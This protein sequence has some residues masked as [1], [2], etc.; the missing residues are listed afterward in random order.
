MKPNNPFL[1]AGYHSPEFFCD[2]KAETATILD[3]LHNG[4]NITLIAPRRMGK[5]GLIHHAFYQL[6]E[7]KV[8]I[9]TLYMDIYSTQTLGDFV[10]L[11]ANT[12]LGQLDSM[13]QKALGRISQFIRS[14]RPVFTFDE[15]T[16]T[17]KVTVDVSPAE[18][19]S[20]LK[21][22][23]D[24]LGS[25][26]KRCYI[27]IDEFQQI[28]EYPEKGVEALLRSYIQ[29]LPNV[30]FIFA[31]SKQHVMQEMFASS[32]RPFYQ[33]TQLLTIGTINRDEYAYF[34]MEHF[35]NHDLKLPREVFDEIYDK[36]DGHTW[37]IQNL[38][39]RLYGYNRNVEMELVS[40]A[41]EQIIT[42]QS[43]SYAD[44][45]KAYSAGHVRLLKAI[46]QEGCVKEVL[47]GDFISKHRLKAA[48]S[49]RSALKKLID[50]EL[51]YQT[52][53]GYIIYDRFMG[54]WLRKQVF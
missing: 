44:L 34:A 39:N 3:A 15:M 35:A 49:V 33:S 12:V 36:F 21:E 22:I 41:V 19:E 26:E 28:A 20:T 25:S 47:A 17:P 2:R 11:F 5:T 6:K 16:G 18:E 50:N 52:A 10:R 13:P 37:Y 30:H 54:E 9:V 43:Y 27:A 8:D 53:D 51:V 31:G 7:Q 4:R 1:I 14:C 45:L 46:A 40:Y 23:F 38:L 24:Y 42:E 48:S 32:K 29:F